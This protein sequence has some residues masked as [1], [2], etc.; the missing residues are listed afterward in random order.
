MS[1]TLQRPS[2]RATGSAAPP[3]LEARGLVKRFGSLLAVDH[4]DFELRPGV[5]ALLGENGAGKST[6]VKILYGYQPADEGQILLDGQPVEIR[7]PADARAHGIGLVFQQS[8][9]IPAL[10][11]TENIALFLPDLPPLLRHREIEAKIEDF[12]RRYGLVVS[13]DR[14][15]GTL[16]LPEQQRVQIL[17][18]LLAGARILIFDEPTS[19]LPAQEID[20]LFDVFRR[21]RDDGYPI[22]LITHRL[23]E[24]FA[25]ADTVTVMRRG[26][27]VATVETADVDEE[28]LV[29]LMFGAAPAV[30]RTGGRETDARRDGGVLELQAVNSAG[31]GRPLFGLDLALAPGEIAGVAGVAGNGQRELADTVVGLARIKSG[32]RLLDGRD[33]SK[34]SVR[35]IRE[36]GVGFVPESALGQELI[37]NMSLRENVALGSARRF[38]RFGG[39]SVDWP[40]VQREWDERIGKLGLDLPDPSNPSGTL[41]GGNAQRL[42][43]A[44]ELARDLRVL[45]TLYPTHGLDVKTTAAV[46][47]LL[48][49]ARDG[50]CAVLLISQDLNELKALSDRLLV[51][52][53]GR[54]VAEV[55]PQTDVYELGRLMTGGELG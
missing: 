40:A 31:Q 21:L 23:A 14:R 32:R 35:R 45:V 42:A 38:S 6:L 17:R 12:G 16:S 19:T 24:V 22:V 52:R 36:A 48:L 29:E 51:M 11:V 44:R 4:A 7:S 43:L 55:D 50:G 18:V 10:T 1:A 9:L 34:W 54:I 8:T 27:V 46:Q 15:A 47:E 28:R 26:S 53:E 37:W 3:P 30:A 13:P 39:L 25:L 5:H 2:A 49:R 41:S 20:A 33:A